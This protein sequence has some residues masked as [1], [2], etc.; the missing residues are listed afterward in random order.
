ML[1]VVITVHVEK[2]VP[3]FRVTHFIPY[4]LTIPVCGQWN[5]QWLEPEY[6]LCL[7]VGYYSTWPWIRLSILSC[8]AILKDLGRSLI[9]SLPIGGEIMWQFFF[10]SLYSFYWGMRLNK[11]RPSG[12]LAQEHSDW[13]KPPRHML[14]SLVV[15]SSINCS[16]DQ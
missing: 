3:D 16:Q 15:Y 4:L 1:A 12:L 9:F 14:I 10:E 2:L 6:W 13:L 5:V 7:S 8:R 11:Y